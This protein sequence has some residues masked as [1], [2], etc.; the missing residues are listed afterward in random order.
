MENIL[1]IPSMSIFN[2]NWDLLLKFME[3]EGNPP[4]HIEGDA[5]LPN[6]LITNLGNLVSVGGNL[7]LV[8]NPIRDLGKLE[9]VGGDLTLHMTYIQSLGN[10]KY[11]A[12]FLDLGYT[13]IKDLGKL[14]FVG[15]DLY[16]DSTPNLKMDR[17]QILDK[18]KVRG[19][20]GRD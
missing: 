14:E 16:L 6:Q 2:N 15:S 18:I 3:N 1:N 13:P 11:V 12:G 7:N 5:E 20:Y 10:L 8:D 9:H 19:I 4:F 17:K